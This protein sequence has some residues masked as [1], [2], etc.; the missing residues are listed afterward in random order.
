MVSI[1]IKIQNIYFLK[2]L[3]MYYDKVTYKV[4]S[5]S[6]AQGTE[7]EWCVYKGAKRHNSNICPLYARTNG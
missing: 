2:K 7:K 6:S 4:H 3:Q 5:L 1:V